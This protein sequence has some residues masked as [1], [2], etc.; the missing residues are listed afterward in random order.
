MIKVVF[1]STPSPS[2]VVNTFFNTSIVFDSPAKA[3]GPGKIRSRDNMRIM[4][5]TPA[6]NIMRPF[7]ERFLYV[8]K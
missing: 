8:Y 6:L 5:W 3:A 1:E 4:D 2:I 7:D